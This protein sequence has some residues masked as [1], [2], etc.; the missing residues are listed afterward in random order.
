MSKP[1]KLI[2]LLKAKP[3]VSKEE[4]KRHWLEEYS[5]LVLKFKNL[6]GYRINIAIDEYQEIEGELPYD[7]TA[8]IWWDSIKEM[9]EDLAS[10]TAE[11]VLANADLF[12]EKIHIYSE[13]YI[14][15]YVTAEI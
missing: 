13:E 8:E 10:S 3:G 14:I 2:S 12:M 6:K 4:F 9:K 1:I 15:K 5:P 7:G 11:E